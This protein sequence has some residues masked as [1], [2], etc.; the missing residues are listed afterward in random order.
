MNK[1]VVMLIVSA[2]A[3][4]IANQV[5]AA[6]PRNGLVA[7]YLFDGSANDTSG[8]GN[9]GTVY[10]AALVPDRF[11]KTN[12]AY[13]FGGTHY[14]GIPGAVSIP[15]N[16]DPYTIDA[17]I[18]PSVMGVNSIIG[19]GSYGNYS[20]INAI[21]LSPTGI[22][23]YWWSNDLGV[24]TIDLREAWHQVTVTYDGQSRKMYLDSELI[25]SDVP[26]EHSVPTASN[27]TIGLAYS[28]QYFNGIL[29]DIRIYNRAL[30]VAE[31][32]DLFAVQSV[33][34]TGMCGLIAAAGVLLVL[35]KRWTYS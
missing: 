11:G 21:R 29:D 7:E 22:I 18:K 6:A 13:N 12:G 30:S 20:Q 33:P 15:I 9:N 19:W 23:H 26:G 31:I 14:I 35:G 28:G 16:N 24:T 25:G 8:N 34:A 27:L 2:F 5:W 32:Q 10:G 4:L 17:W 1:V 3:I